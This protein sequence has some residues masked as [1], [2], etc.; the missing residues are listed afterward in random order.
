MPDDIGDQVASLW[1][2]L[3]AERAASRDIAERRKREARAMSPATRRGAR[4]AETKSAQINI[5]VTPSLK[6]HIGAMA[7][8]RGVTVVELIETAIRQLEGMP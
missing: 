4:R 5:R 1:E 3:K 2:Q 6:K 8:A 7:D